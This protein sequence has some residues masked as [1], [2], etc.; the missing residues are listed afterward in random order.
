VS[1]TSRR[2]FGG[3]TTIETAAGTLSL[4]GLLSGPDQAII[5]AWLLPAEQIPAPS[6]Q[7]PID[8]LSAALLNL[9]AAHQTP[10]FDDVT[11]TDDHGTNYILRLESLS[12]PFGQSGEA[13]RLRL[14]LVPVLARE[15]GWLDLRNRDGATTRLWPS[16]RPSVRVGAPTP[17]AGSPAERELTEQALSVIEIYLSWT[18]ED[19]L[20]QQCA[21]AIA[22]VTEVR[23]RL[24]TASELP[25]QLTRLCAL[26][27]EE[28]P[29][30]GLPPA[31][32]GMLDAA[33]RTDGPDVHLDIAA[34]LPSI[35]DT[36]VQVDSLISEP[37]CWRLHL[38]ATPGWW[39]YSEDRRQKWTVMS[40][41]A[42]DNLGGM[43]LGTFGGSSGRGDHEE[44]TV[45]F[46]PRLDPLARIL[47]L[48]FSATGEQ[49]S[50]DL[51]LEPAARP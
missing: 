18:D 24:D 37:E 12:V 34:A 50:L 11:V 27:C 5:D 40:V 45:R 15:C 31:W 35:A 6:G 14:R 23:G 8:Q 2:S 19:F 48:T 39:L 51:G 1:A 36:E 46:L 49:V 7:T 33:R 22:K 10:G 21:T 13:E 29:A 44:V 32:S 41:R 9:S 16:G 42:E 38:R 17:V 47:K 43:Y 26:L 28:Q 30:D 3:A 4:I 20:R 25:D